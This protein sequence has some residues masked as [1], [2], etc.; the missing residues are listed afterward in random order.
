MW[1]VYILNFWDRIKIWRTKNIENRIKEVQ[2]ASWSIIQDTFYLK[3]EKYKCIEKIMHRIFSLYRTRWEYFEDI[4]FEDI[5]MILKEI[6]DIINWQKKDTKLLMQN[7]VFEKNWEY[8]IKSKFIK[9]Y[10]NWNLEKLI[11]ISQI[12]YFTEL[13]STMDSKNRIDFSYLWLKEWTLNKVRAEFIKKWIVWEFKLKWDWK[14]TYYLN[15]F[16]ASNWK[17]I[18][19]ELFEAFFEINNW[20]IY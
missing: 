7:Y 11:W 6:N 10:I 5:I 20:K 19:N 8:Q 16:Y 12:W 2:N 14:K 9:I 13:A 17:T 4:W 15:P 1:Y 18:S 3:F